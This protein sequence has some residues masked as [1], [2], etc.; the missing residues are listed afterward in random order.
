MQ[1]AVM[2]FAGMAIAGWRCTVGSV[3]HHPWM[4][5]HGGVVGRKRVSIR[6]VALGVLLLAGIATGSWWWS[7]RMQPDPIDQNPVAA[8]GFVVSSPSC[9]DGGGGTVVDVMPV[10]GGQVRAVIDACGYSDGQQVAVE[11]LAG[12]P[13]QARLAGTSSASGTDEVRQWWPI[14]LG[15]LVVLAAGIAVVLVVDR[16]RFRRIP[17]APTRSPVRSRVQS[18]GGHHT[19]PAR[20]AVSEIAEIA[21]AAEDVQAGAGAAVNPVDP[22]AQPTAMVSTTADRVVPSL[23]SVGGVDAPRGGRHAQQE[24][25]ADEHDGWVS[26]A[27]DDGWL[28]TMND[29]GWLFEP[30]PS[31]SAEMSMGGDGQLPPDD[32]GLV[33]FRLDLV[34]TSTAEL[35][36]SLHD[37]L[38]THRHAEVSGG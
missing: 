20:H 21:G 17:G 23:T 22:I 3:C 14:A 1:F 33:P 28:P 38:F 12:D 25:E 31:W 27:N 30:A 2:Q 29:D 7:L 35:A 18:I 24:A 15:V 19:G 37:E 10:S 32:S 36:A 6:A 16:R 5:K 13:S 4:G 34:F 26:N 11:Y 9:T 8:A